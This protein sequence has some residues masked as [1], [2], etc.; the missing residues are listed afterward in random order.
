MTGLTQD[1]RKRI[2]RQE[3][4]ARLAAPSPAGAPYFAHMRLETEGRVTDLLLGA[5]TR[6]A[7]GL[8]IID[9]QRSPLAEV[10]F[11]CAEGEEYEIE[12]GGRSLGGLLLER[13]LL[14]FE[15]GELVEL[16]TPAC[17]FSRRG[18]GEWRREQRDL[19]L[20][21]SARPPHLR[22]RASPI[23]VELDEAQRRAVELPA[24][25][26]LLVLGEAGC[27]K[28]TVALHRLAHLQRRVKAARRAAVIVPTDG[29]RRLVESFLGRLGIRA[30]VWLY[31]R[32]AAQLAR[33]AFPD[34][35]RAESAAATAGVVRIKRHP[36]LRP[37]LREL[38]ALPPA[39][40]DDD[41][42]APPRP[43]SA[44][45]AHADLQA[46]FGDSAYMD[47]LCAAD[48]T[49]TRRMIA[50]VLEH[51]R[52]QF[53][54][55]A[56]EE[57]AHVDADRLAT[58][59]GR[60]LDEGT[61]MEDARTVDVEDY[62]VLFELDRLRAEAK[63]TKPAPVRSYDCI[64]LDETQEL[65]PLELALVGRALAEGGTLIVAGDANQQVDPTAAFAGW[66]AAMAELG[67]ADHE[68][69]VLD[70]SYR[71]PPEVIALARRVL[72]PSAPCERGAGAGVIARR[73]DNE[74][75]QVA[76]LIDALRA[77]QEIDPA[78]SL[79]IIARTPETARRL[80]ALLRR[81]LGVR[82]AL[83]GDFDLLAGI[84]VTCVQEVKGLEFD[85]VVVPDASA[86]AYGGTAQAR[87]A[88]YVAL[89]RA[90]RQLA[91]SAVGDWSPLALFEQANAGAP[92]AGYSSGRARETHPLV[93]PK[94]SAR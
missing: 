70:V 23:E 46:L 48:P 56:E 21:L 86:G 29:L 51:T 68:R 73:F 63:G 57:W 20:K 88:L 1:E 76:W 27:G 35:P 61:P 59:D 44:N 90:T 14:S 66:D 60:S 71:C 49:V 34:L 79:A 18:S 53:C 94:S 40:P 42:D 69:A 17:L 22:S 77:L 12:A 41:G 38:A 45:A 58:L 31:D 93:G 16:A 89:T 47:R 24:G 64:V 52:V 36:A 82:L 87:R 26:A 91:L 81:G 65:A 15:R 92:C 50:E 55:T 10:F 6:L 25:R 9:W 11:S 72:D 19:A 5:E 39:K 43:S 7:A 78:I 54:P 80:A 74:L 85:T 62:A 67:C 83:E 8:S 4:L 28:T 2:E 75:H 30:E 32:W 33:R 3:Q 37:I 84:N 13:N